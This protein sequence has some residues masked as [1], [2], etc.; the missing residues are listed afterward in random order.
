[1]SKTLKNKKNNFKNILVV[2]IFIYFLCIVFGKRLDNMY[3][4]WNLLLAWI[5]LEISYFF[6]KVFGHKNRKKYSQTLIVLLSIIWV[7]SYPNAPY[8]ITEL[9]YLNGNKYFELVN[10]KGTGVIFKN[11]LNIWKDFFYVF[12]GVWICSIISFVSIH[13]NRKIIMERYNSAFSWIFLFLVAIF[14][15]FNMYLSRIEQ[16][17]S[18]NII[19]NP[20][21]TI[22]LIY[23]NINKLTFEFS[24]LFAGI[25]IIMYMIT[26]L[27]INKLKNE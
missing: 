16:I 8:V 19:I 22:V 18:W 24:M 6:K 14:S 1:M 9:V 25:I 15:G 11:D 3:M 12:I 20:Y 5:P 4:I 13:I 23:K 10:S 21:K 17:R 27:L 26:N 2:V 7:I